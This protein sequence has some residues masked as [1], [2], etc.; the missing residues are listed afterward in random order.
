MIARLVVRHPHDAPQRRVFQVRETTRYDVS[1][2]LAGMALDESASLSERATALDILK[3]DGDVGVLSMLEPLRT[4]ADAE[5]RS[6]A[7]TACLQ[8]EQRKARGARSMTK[9]R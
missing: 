6:H 1:P 5:L 9:P 2:V 4:A 7:L 3:T 8:I